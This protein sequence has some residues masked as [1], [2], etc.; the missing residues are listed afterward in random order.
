MN[1][2]VKAISDNVFEVTVTTHAS[3]LAKTLMAVESALAVEPPS[4]PVP[5][6]VTTHNFV[7]KKKRTRKEYKELLESLLAKGFSYS[8][9]AN[10]MRTQGFKSPKGY[11][12]TRKT[13]YQYV[14][15]KTKPLS[16][17]IGSSFVVGV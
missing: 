7:P 15:A 17:D 11:R 12:I 14:W 8:K 16:K 1:V 5:P 3:T 4:I 10:I 6:P 13:I 9:I 2:K